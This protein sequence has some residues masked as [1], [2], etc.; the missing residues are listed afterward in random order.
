[1]CSGFV[2]Y[3][4][5]YS[6]MSC[7]GTIILFIPKNF[8]LTKFHK[9]TIYKSGIVSLPKNGKISCGVSLPFISGSWRVSC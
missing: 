4:N 9:K 7:R 3:I 2:L 6:V 8:Q 1:M 5:F